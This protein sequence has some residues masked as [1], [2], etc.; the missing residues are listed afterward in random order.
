ML[1]ILMF[2]FKAI[3]FVFTLPF[4]II[5]WI[6]TTII[7]MLIKIVKFSWPLAIVGLIVY[8]VISV[9]APIIGIYVGIFGITGAIG[10]ALIGMFMGFGEATI[11]KQRHD[12]LVDA[13]KEKK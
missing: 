2:P 8:C 7:T 4:R 5:G 6:W 3:W 13:I 1:K 11:E 9:M 10:I 12:E